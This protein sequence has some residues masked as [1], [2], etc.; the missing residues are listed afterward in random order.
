MRYNNIQMNPKSNSGIFVLVL[1]VLAILSMS[2]IAVK[3][4]RSPLGPA[5]PATPTP[6]M[7]NNE[8]AATVAP[9]QQPANIC[10]E[11]TVWNLLIL[12]S[13]VA[14]MRGEKGSDFVRLLR[15]D[16][17]NR[18]VTI[19][20]FPRNLWVDAAGLGLMNPTVNATQLGTVFYEARS[21]SLKTNVKE[22]MID[23]TDATARMLAQNFL[24]GT[25][26]YLTVD[27]FQ[28]PAMVD[29]IGGIPINVPQRTTDPWIGTVIEAGPQ[30]LNGAQFVAYARAKPDSDFGRI[31][32]N[33]LLLAA[34]REKLLDPAI[35][36]KVPQLYA[37]FS[38]TIA[39]DLSPEQINHL[40]CLL[41]EIPAETIIQDQVRQEWTSLGPQ[42]GSLL[43]DKTAVLNRLKE[44]GLTP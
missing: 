2:V 17:P 32:R 8:V 37:Q 34:L 44:L 7:A 36:G 23:G 38:E 26:H 19:F 14:Y 13:D 18:R 16:F 41:Q 33:N 30:I 28:I 21:R 12:G 27:Q 15:V 10:G 6:I 25:D 22:T 40:S 5:L 20:A 29:A 24:V 42:P 31:Q 39:T 11:T 3:A 9:A 4:Y 1:V 43:W 35:W